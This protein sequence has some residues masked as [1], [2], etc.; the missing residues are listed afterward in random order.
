[1]PLQ[2]K[3][4]TSQQSDN[5]NLFFIVTVVKS[6][7]GDVNKDGKI[8]AMDARLALR[9]AAKIDVPTEYQAKAANYNKDANITA[10]DAGLI[11]RKSAKLD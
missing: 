4:R 1:M 5:L 3:L 6:L 8:T 2:K 11:L 10:M 9:I 7:L